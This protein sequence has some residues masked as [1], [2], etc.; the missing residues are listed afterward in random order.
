MRSTIVRLPTYNPPRAPEWQA[1][2]FQREAPLF[3][4]DAATRRCNAASGEY[5][6]YRHTIRSA[7]LDALLKSIGD[8][9]AESD[10]RTCCTAGGSLSQ[11]LVRADR[12][13]SVRVWYLSGGVDFIEGGIFS[14][15]TL[16]SSPAIQHPILGPPAVLGH[17]SRSRSACHN[18]G[19]FHRHRRRPEQLCHRAG[20]LRRWHGLAKSWHRPDRTAASNSSPDIGA[21]LILGGRTKL[22]PEKVARRRPAAIM[23]N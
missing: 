17:L 2:G 3:Y 13:D 5:R 22:H 16:I 14:P 19:R 12:S 4:S 10:V 1:P 11:S 15:G 8:V 21:E 6:Q 9:L 18:T 23:W 20:A 7:S